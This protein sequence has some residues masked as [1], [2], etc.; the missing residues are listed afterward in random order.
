MQSSIESY[1]NQCIEELRIA[2]DNENI[3]YSKFIVADMKK[4]MDQTTVFCDLLSSLTRPPEEILD[5]DKLEELVDLYDSN[6]MNGDVKRILD[7]LSECIDDEEFSSI[8]PLL[9][10]LQEMM[11]KTCEFCFALKHL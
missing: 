2:N 7:S 1:I 5:L 3:S 4:I 10:Q 9:H 6:T 8:I 11:N